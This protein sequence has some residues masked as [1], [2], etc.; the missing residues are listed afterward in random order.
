MRQA[1][2]AEQSTI[3]TRA[4][5]QQRH[6]VRNLMTL[7]LTARSP[8]P[9]HCGAGG[10]TVHTACC[11]HAAFLSRCWLSTIAETDRVTVRIEGHALSFDFLFADRVP[12]G[13]ISRGRSLSDSPLE[14]QHKLLYLGSRCRQFQQASCRRLGLQAICSGFLQLRKSPMELHAP[15]FST[16]QKIVTTN[17][18]HPKRSIN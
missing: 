3:F 9:W 12:P 16:L 10:V 18:R 7:P 4:S 15:D 8:P 14:F 11:T 2:T 1:P 13:R 5:T 17:L 6:V